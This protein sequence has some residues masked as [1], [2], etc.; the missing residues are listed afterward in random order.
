MFFL[1]IFSVLTSVDESV[2][3]YVKIIVVKVV[4]SVLLKWSRINLK[5]VVTLDGELCGNQYERTF[6]SY[7]FSRSFSI[8]N[9]WWTVQVDCNY[10]PL[11][12]SPSHLFAVPIKPCILRTVLSDLRNGHSNPRA[13]L[14]A[15]LSKIIWQ[16]ASNQ[17]WNSHW[18]KI[19]FTSTAT[20]IREV[21]ESL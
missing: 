8:S 5:L 10:L 18:S 6:Y 13:G 11:N 16:S 19:L 21:E 1:I 9:P 14:Y 12:D 4:I 2:K 3:L 20:E 15:T 17:E 7:I